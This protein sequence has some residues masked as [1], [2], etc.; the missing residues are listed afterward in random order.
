MRQ[1]EVAEERWYF[2]MTVI[3]SEVASWHKMLLDLSPDISI[4]STITEFVEETILFEYMDTMLAFASKQTVA[5]MTMQ[6]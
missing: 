1:N 5:K 4:A 2:G 3:D 6:I